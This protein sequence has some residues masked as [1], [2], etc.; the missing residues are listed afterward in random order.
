MAEA[1]LR[2]APTAAYIAA[3]VNLAAGAVMLFALRHGIPAGEK[4]LSA[5][6]AYV[7][8]H[9]T[10]W[11][12]GWL[13]WNFAA[14]SLLGFFVALAARWRHQAPILCG[15]ALLCAAGGLAADLGA[16]TVLAA[17]SPGLKG[18]TFA[19]VESI[20]VALTGYL[21]NGL[22][23]VGGILLTVAGRLE[24]PPGL[25]WLAAAVW[26]AAVW[27]SVATLVSSAA[28]RFASAAALMPLFVLWAA[29][30]GRWLSGRAS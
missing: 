7:A 26:A 16:E 30:T 27:L 10:A 9:T 21:G 11:R 23:A 17:V 5:R 14:I 13:V 6:I 3:A 2:H 12:I 29:L 19:L 20:A 1:R 24:L 8:E 28:G 25:L 18:E 4:D 22:Y 15:L